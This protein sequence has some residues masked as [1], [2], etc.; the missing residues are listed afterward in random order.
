MLPL[1]LLT[2]SLAA[3]CIWA[4]ADFLALV[5]GAGFAIYALS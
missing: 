3:L 5:I 1:A 2:L 4:D